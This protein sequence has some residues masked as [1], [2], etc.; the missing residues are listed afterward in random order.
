MRYADRCLVPK[1]S[2]TVLSDS[3]WDAIEPRTIQA[4][5]DNVRLDNRKVLN[6]ILYV[7]ANGRKWR[8]LPECHGRRRAVYTRM[9]CWSR[10]EDKIVRVQPSGAVWGVK[11]TPSGFVPDG[12]LVW[13]VW[14]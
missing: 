7:A 1:F 6:A 5:R 12:V 11:K 4:E 9:M 3:C 14:R 13:G 10:A 2:G 8:A